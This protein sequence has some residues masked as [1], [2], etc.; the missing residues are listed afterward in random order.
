MI[1]GMAEWESVEMLTTREVA[2][3]LDAAPGQVR[4]WCIK[5]VFPNAQRHDT[6]RGPVW[7]IPESD[8]QGF[9][10]RGPGRPSKTDAEGGSARSRRNGGASRTLAKK[11]A[12]ERNHKK[13]AK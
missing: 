11:Q 3:R 10:R 7:Y 13:R 2:E 8:L 5:G 4:G 9:R 6:V 1:C 12:S